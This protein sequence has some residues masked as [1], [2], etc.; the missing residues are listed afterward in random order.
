MGPE[1]MLRNVFYHQPVQLMLRLGGKLV[2]E[3][4][5]SL[6]KIIISILK[7]ATF[8]VLVFPLT[9]VKRQSRN[10]FP[11]IM[12]YPSLSLFDCKDNPPSAFPAHPQNLQL[13][14]HQSHKWTTMVSTRS[15]VP[16][17][18]PGSILKIQKQRPNPTCCY[19]QK[20]INPKPGDHRVAHKI[21]ARNKI[22][23][24]SC[25]LKLHRAKRK[26]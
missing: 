15:S 6:S 5:R 4:H 22:S 2:P 19:R 24:R 13:H 3:A 14:T 10:H 11:K 23:A 1:K 8:N 21:A 9:T 26:K 12:S 7:Y 20:V 25:N 18:V 17:P 16:I